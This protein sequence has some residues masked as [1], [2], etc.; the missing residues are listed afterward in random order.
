MSATAYG[1]WL[2]VNANSNVYSLSQ[3][4]LCHLQVLSDL[5]TGK[6]VQLSMSEGA[7]WRK[8]AGE[9]SPGDMESGLQLVHKLFASNVTPN[10]EDLQ[11]VMS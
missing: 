4:G 8:F 10:S 2:Q 6:R 3:A 5:L 7:Y 11:T 9:D 1:N